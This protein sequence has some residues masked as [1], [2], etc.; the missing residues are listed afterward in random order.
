MSRAEADAI[1]YQT[2]V[3]FLSALGLTPAEAAELIEKKPK[4]PAPDMAGALDEGE[5]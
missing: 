1:R 3:Y 4:P 5:D 2:L